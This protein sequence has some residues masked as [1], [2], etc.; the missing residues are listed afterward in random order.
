MKRLFLFLIGIMTTY[1][2]W[3]V[4]A[5][6]T[7]F[8]VR[9][10]D[11][12]EI[13]VMQVGDE[14]FHFYINVETGERLVSDDGMNFR[15]MQEAEFSQRRSLSVSRRAPAHR[16]AMRDGTSLDLKGKR[17][18]LV[19][20]VNFS[21]VSYTATRER[22]DDQMNKAGFSENGHIGSVRDYF[23]AQSYGQFEVDFDVVGPITMPQSMAYYGANNVITGNDA[24]A[25]EMVAEA[26]TAAYGR[27]VNFADYD[28]N[29]DGEAEMVTVIYAGYGEAQS[30]NPR[31]I[32]PHQWYLSDAHDYN[33]SDGPGALDFDGTKVDKYLVLNE[34]NGRYGK[35]IDG[36]GTFCHEF[37]HSLDLPDIYDTNYINFGMNCWSVMD[38]GSYNANGSI[39][40]GYTAY[41]R[42]FCGWLEPVELSEGTTVTDMPA[43]NDEPV[44][45]IVYNDA[46]PTEYYLLYNVQQKGWDAA[47]P[48]HGMLIMHVDYNAQAW[49]M[50]SVNT[51]GSRQ[52]V[53]IFHADNDDGVGQVSLQG[54]PFP[55]VQNVTEFTDESLPPASLY[56][57]NTDGTKLMHKPITEIAES[58]TDAGEATIS[59]KFMGGEP[60][61]VEAP[62]APWAENV[63]E[64]VF[65][66]A[67]NPI[68]DAN[69]T[70][71]LE[72]VIASVAPS[73]D[74]GTEAGAPAALS[75]RFAQ[76]AG[77]SALQS[78]ERMV[79]G[80][81]ETRY[82][83]TE[84]PDDCLV[85]FRVQAVDADGNPSEWSVAETVA[86]GSLT[87]VGSVLG[88][89]C[90][91]GDGT[92]REKKVFD[93]QGRR[94]ARLS[95]HGFYIED[96][97]KRI[98]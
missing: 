18:A 76:E 57:R 3:A 68:S 34:L 52:R 12:T 98:R 66:V 53:T 89:A 50:N 46:V 1:M 48:G 59:F 21:D 39:P 79:E 33:N 44:A 62:A 73:P 60:V 84:L 72:L 91:K 9:Q 92:G 63:G 14:W 78:E 10:A 20:L 56:N 80:L 85:T 24:H 75:A 25:A 23:L 28:W 43:L 97:Q 38:R 87:G 94:I 15:P 58:N 49:N 7:V 69:A 4:P 2:L 11:G 90:G 70:Y 22:M 95:R 74:S 37:S 67:W 83:V 35:V 55:G 32:W 16:V 40:C 51:V 81:T 5:K 77:E 19:L 27:G 86:F 17:R 96:G 26:C 64:R 41:E 61:Y 13:S 71:N 31:H 54:D 65:T 8:T 93:L 30:S 29:G 88:E 45:Y 42:K 6:P 47:A 36:I 82:E